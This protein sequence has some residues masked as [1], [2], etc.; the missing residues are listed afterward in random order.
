MSWGTPLESTFVGRFCLIVEFFCNPSEISSTAPS[1]FIQQMFILVSA[2]LCPG[3]NSSSLSSQISQC[4]TFIYAGF[5]PL[6][7]RSN[8][9]HVIAPATT[10]L[11]N[12][13]DTC[14][15]LNSFSFME[16]RT[17][18]FISLTRV[19]CSSFTNHF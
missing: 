19:D 14:H 11:P 13:G 12:I 15:G 6:T 16:C 8:A 2:A 9:Q 3:S 18:S 1:P 10:M 7:E 5:K 4:C 17:L